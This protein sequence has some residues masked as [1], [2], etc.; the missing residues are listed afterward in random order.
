[1]EGEIKWKGEDEKSDRGIMNIKYIKIKDLKYQ[2]EFEDSDIEEEFEKE[3]CLQ[4]Y[5][6][7]ISVTKYY[8]TYI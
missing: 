3:K 5:I 4:R 8:N 7:N 2:E 6:L 1:M